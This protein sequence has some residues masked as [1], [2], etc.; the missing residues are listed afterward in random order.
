MKE[1]IINK[2]KELLKY[3]TIEQ[4]PEEFTKIFE[5]IKQTTSPKLNIQ[6]YTFNNKKSLVISNNKSKKQ[7]IIFCTHIDIVPSTSYEYTEDE[8]NIYGRGTI[9]MKGSV[10]VC[11]ELLNN[12][13]SPYKIALF[14]TS[15]EE[16]DGNCVYELLKIYNTKLAIVP[17]GGT[18]FQLIKEEKGLLQLE[19]S[20]KT[21][22]AH[23]SQPF[24]GEN[25]IVKL[26]DVYNNLISK[27][28]LPKSTKEYITSI[29]LS[30][31]IGGNATN[32]VPDNASMK[33][34]IR[35]ISTDTKEDIIKLIKEINHNI[36]IKIIL[37]GN[38][39]KTNIDNPSIQKYLNICKKHLNK[40]IKIVG[41]ESTS[42]AIYFSNKNIPT[43]IM[44][45]KGY[46]PHCENEY[47]EKDS[48]LIL[49]NIYKEFIQE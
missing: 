40:E 38:V 49:Y 31:I 27:Y 14:I 36:D 35:N 44:N 5:Y 32:Q 8:N 41:C 12:I 30:T 39:F 28:P 4:N 6:E 43:I 24:N 21:K 15:D 46:Y 25:A 16:I 11:L 37:E 18:N 45:P 33:L 29:N 20:I 2:L 48:L 42:D 17:D 22:S 3:K 47:V 13:E 7:D 19:L 9:D 26:F 34:D 1:N 23:A 10:A